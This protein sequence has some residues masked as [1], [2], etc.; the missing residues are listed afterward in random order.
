MHSKRLTRRQFLRGA[1]VAGVGLA[2]AACATPP[3]PA[4]TTAPIGA[5]TVVPPA[6]ATK[7]KIVVGM[8]RPLSGWNSTVGDAAFRPIYETWIPRIN[9][10]GGVYVAEYGK[11][12]PIEMIIYDDT[13]DYG[14]TAR[15]TEKLILEDKVDFLWPAS[16]T[17]FIFAQA[18]IANKYGYLLITAEGGATQIK[19]MLPSLPYVF[20]TLSFSDWYQLPV[21]ADILSA[22]GAKTAY[23]TYIADLH[24]IEYSGVA[25]I[26]FPKKGI[27][28]VGSKS[29]PP[30]IKDLSPVIKAAQASEADIFCCFA[31][32]DQLMPATGTSIEL[33]YNP[34]AWVGGPGINFG[35]YH[36]AFGP[37]VEGVMGFSCFA[38]GSSPALDEMADIL[39]KGKPEDIQD[40][41]GHPFYWASLD[42][43]KTAIET[44]G[45]LNQEKVRDVI[46]SASADK[47][48][49]TVLGPTWFTNGLLAKEAHM[50]EIGQWVNGVYQV[51]GPTDKATA[52]LVYPKPAW[53]T[54]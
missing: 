16:G 37:M 36:T 43:W 5:P 53:P 17:G 19:D 42:I 49:Q 25:G 22:K 10:A 31:Y 38:R 45:T 33:G 29:L 11:K 47:P 8:A 7:D 30:D 3:A 27:E 41:W 39:Y 35:F 6:K 4:P 21:L 14:T 20:V 12:L 9:E 23:V 54:G 40:W 15:L 13:S 46:A 18:P 51:V 24:G 52:E 1:A 26:E 32:P 48:L 34:K 2:A 28:I 44:A 50:G